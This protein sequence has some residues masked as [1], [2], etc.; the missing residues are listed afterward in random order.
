MVAKI[1]D[2]PT[3]INLSPEKLRYFGKKTS[4]FKNWQSDVDVELIWNPAI[5]TSTLVK[6]SELLR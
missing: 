6:T 5:S 2:I 3:A 4:S 1:Q